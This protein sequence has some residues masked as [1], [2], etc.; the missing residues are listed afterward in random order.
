MTPA[1]RDAG[2]FCILTTLYQ[3][4]PMVDIWSQE[5]TVGTWLRVE[6]A[7]AVAQAEE[8]VLEKAHADAIAAV[9]DAGRIDYERLWKEARNV[10]Y[11]ILPLVRQI[12]EALPEGPDGRVHYGAT[13]QDIMDTGLALQLAAAADRAASLL[14][15]FGDAADRLAD[16]HSTTVMA[17][18]THAQQAVPTTFGAKMAVFVDDCARALDE[19][20]RAKDAACA[21]SLFGAGGTAAAYG[22]GS[23]RIR[24][25]MADDLGL[26]Y[27]D[28]PWHVARAGIVRLG[29]VLATVAATCTRFARE[30]IDLSRSEIAEVH[31]A[32]G[33][34]RGASSTMPQKAN[35]ISSESIVGLSVTA[36]AL[37]TALLRCMEAGHER[38]AGE[39]QIEWLIVPQICVLTATALALAA[40]TAETL[41]VSPEAMSGNLSADGG[42]LLSEAAMMRLAPHTGREH[43]HDLVYEAATRARATGTD[44]VG[45]LQDV[46]PAD[47]LRLVDGLAPDGYLGEAP[48]VPARARG[49][50][51]AAVA[52]SQEEA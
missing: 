13:T 31:E 12:A 34:H 18:R 38:S 7:L 19:L 51:R 15:R 5:A 3:D 21:I 41:V 17:A 49:R 4:Q 48:S 40:E 6:R 9:C 1:G 43:A 36:G 46:L 30:V 39:W 20:H 47:T 32:A 26:A 52:K 33:H 35:P 22:A 23:E 14:V 24:I 28:V 16:A 8:G 45:A 10:G 25:R 44:L 29:F 50:W 42:L 37:S 11:P 27:A 2:V